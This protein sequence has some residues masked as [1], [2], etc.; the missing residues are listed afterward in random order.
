MRTDTARDPVRNPGCSGHRLRPG[1]LSC[2][3]AESCHRIPCRFPTRPGRRR[4]AGSKVRS[5]MSRNDCVPVRPGRPAPPPRCSPRSRHARRG[6]RVEGR[7]R[8]PHPFRVRC[9]SPPPPRPPN[10]SLT[11]SR[12]WAVFMAERVTDLF[13]MRD[14]VIAELQGLPE[15][16]SRNPGR[17]VGAVRRRPGPGRYSGPRPAL[18]VAIATTLGGPTSHTAIIARQLGIPCVVAATGLD[19]IPPGRRSW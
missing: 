3:A 9:R 16:G 11:C 15:P 4:S 6:P 17:A 7:C 19:D 14:R 18:V 5:P 2:S 1:H 8:H 13:D 10:S 12:R